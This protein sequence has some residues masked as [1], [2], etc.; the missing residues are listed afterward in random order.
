MSIAVQFLHTHLIPQ[1]KLSKFKY[2]L[3]SKVAFCSTH[4]IPG[5]IVNQII[6]RIIRKKNHHV[7]D[8]GRN[9]QKTLI[10]CFEHK[11]KSWN[12]DSTPWDAT[13]WQL[14]RRERWNWLT[15]W[16]VSLSRI[17]SSNPASPQVAAPPPPPAGSRVALGVGKSWNFVQ[18]WKNSKF[19]DLLQHFYRKEFL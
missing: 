5:K 8:W 4:F 11:N 3:E 9:T 6:F 15:R 18:F 10:F 16:S 1:W 19:C 2:T 13:R 17:V 12:R 7:R 14:L